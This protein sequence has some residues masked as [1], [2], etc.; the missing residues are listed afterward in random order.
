MA[1]NCLQ[2]GKAFEGRLRSPCCSDKCVNQRWR[3]RQHQQ[4]ICQCGQ[5]I[6]SGYY[7]CASCREKNSHYQRQRYKDRALRGRCFHCENQAEPGLRL[8][9]RH[10]RDKASS[11]AQRGFSACAYCK[12]QS[13][14]WGHCPEYARD[15]YGYHPSENYYDEPDR[16]ELDRVCGKLD[17]E[18]DWRVR[19]C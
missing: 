8:C 4:G 18:D 16:D 13:H 2:C 1:R 9:A 17:A 10:R 5:P 19:E 6:L 11:Q 3:R 14:P 15:V 12:T 7:H